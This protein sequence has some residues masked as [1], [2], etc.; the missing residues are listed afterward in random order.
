MSR[1]ITPRGR[2]SWLAARKQTWAA[3]KL[4]T[5]MVR[6]PILIPTHSIRISHGERP[7]K[8]ASFCCGTQGPQSVTADAA[9]NLGRMARLARFF[10]ALSSDERG[11]PQ[12]K[13]IIPLIPLRRGKH[14][15]GEL[16]PSSRRVAAIKVSTKLGLPL[17]RRFPRGFAGNSPAIRLPAWT[18]W[19]SLIL[20]RADASSSDACAT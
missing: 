9:K 16:Q 1:S 2:P 12:Q 6:E 7:D 19:V 15:G 13:P 4:A 3:S 5:F 17:D 10:A 8:V 14:A 18:R 20:G 11:F